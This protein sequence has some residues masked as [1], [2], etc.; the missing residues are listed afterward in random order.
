MARILIPTPLRPYAGGQ[1]EV[2]VTGATVG[3]VLTALTVEFAGLWNHLYN[4]Q[5]KLRSFVNVYLAVAAAHRNG[6][7]F[8]L[9]I[10]RA[11]GEGASVGRCRSKH[12]RPPAA[13]SSRVV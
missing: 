6:R 5:G 8:F 1:K 13:K 2:E 12:T 9:L 7:S 11:G 10:R 3:E 4:D